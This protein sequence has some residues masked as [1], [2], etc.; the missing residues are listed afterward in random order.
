[1]LHQFI[2]ETGP[3]AGGCT[4]AT[5]EAVMTFPSAPAQHRGTRRAE[6]PEQR[7]M[8]QPWLGANEGR[9]ASL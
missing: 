6:Y 1:M 3:V 8:G 4:S 9:S 5:L 2:L 7:L